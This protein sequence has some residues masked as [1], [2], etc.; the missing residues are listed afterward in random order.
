MKYTAILIL[1]FVAAGTIAPQPPAEKRSSGHPAPD[2]QTPAEMTAWDT[3]KQGLADGDAA[4]R[5]TAIAAVGTIGPVPE[6]VKL[7]CSGLQDKDATVRQTAAETLGEM[8][9]PDA[10]PSLKTALDDNNPQVSYTAAKALWALGDRTGREIFQEVL[11]G[12]RKDAP[13][14]IHEA[15]KKKLSPGQ[16][17]LMGADSAGGVFLGPA[18]IGITAIH[19]AIKDTRGDTGA[20]GRAESAAELAK[21]QDPYALTLLEWALGDS[22]WAVRLAVAKA[23]GD[24]GN[25]DTIPKL[26]SL[27]QDDRHAVRYMAAASMVKLSSRGVVQTTQATDSLSTASTEGTRTLQQR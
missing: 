8:G 14:K 24:R 12:E 18:S 13:S 16:L 25:Q 19:E 11:T 23:L 4:H 5:K 17:A 10:I 2:S 22:N 1:L 21:D 27:L 3:L 7:V 26:S 6:A 9:S 15:I 20:P